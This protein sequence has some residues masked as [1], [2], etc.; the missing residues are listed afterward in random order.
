MTVF[1]NKYTFEFQCF[2]RILYKN[3][4]LVLLIISVH[5]TSQSMLHIREVFTGLNLLMLAAA[6]HT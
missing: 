1:L 4:E 2:L 3:L 6:C 5:Q